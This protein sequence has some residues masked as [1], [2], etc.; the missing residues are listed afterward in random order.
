MNLLVYKV[1][2]SWSTVKKAAVLLSAVMVLLA[3]SLPLF[4]QAA[5]GTILGGCF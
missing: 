4:S 3:A 1:N 5:V 2:Q